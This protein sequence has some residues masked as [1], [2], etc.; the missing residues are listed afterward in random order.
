MKQ[1]KNQK[2]SRTKQWLVPSKHNAHRPHLLRRHGLIAVALV[3]ISLQLGYNFIVAGKPKIL[4]YATNVSSQAVTDDINEARKKN[5]ATALS[6]DDQLN[7]AASLKA[8]DMLK[9]GY[10]S[11]N[12]P[13]GV[14]PW[15]W[16]EKAGYKYQN[17][18]ENLAKDFQSSRGVESAWLSSQT[19]RENI[20]NPVFKNVGVAVVNGTLQGKETTLV[21]AFFGTRQSEISIANSSSGSTTSVTTSSGSN[22]FANPAQIDVLMNP[23]SILTMLILVGVLAVALLTHWHYV[24]LPKKLRKSW[25]RHHA[26]YTAG[27]ALMFLNYSA[28]IFTSGN[29]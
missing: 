9:N 19:H 18:G 8:D 7:K 20:L 12:S 23:I 10:W 3:L 1:K 25:Y 22:I 27:L 24:K 14:Q 16:F 11:H 6:T 2:Q 4:G 26:L 21:V 15:A 28:Y 29:I 5:G 13:S 17:A